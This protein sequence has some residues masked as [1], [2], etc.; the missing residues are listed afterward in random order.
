[1]KEFTLTNIILWLAR[2]GL[3]AVGC[4]LM[5]L[6]INT[7][8]FKDGRPVFENLVLRKV[9]PGPFAGVLITFSLDWFRDV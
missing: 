1:M 2:G 8:F 6:F 3:M 5:W 7:P 4:Y 9:A